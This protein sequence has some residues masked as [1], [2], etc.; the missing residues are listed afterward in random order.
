MSPAQI[1]AYVDAASALLDLTIETA[2]RPGV[3]RYFGL[4]ADMAALVDA[5]PLEPHHEAA[6]HFTPI[7]PRE[8][9]A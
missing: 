9:E 6:V 4:A 8:G 5:V 1:E 7:S 3:L 2:H